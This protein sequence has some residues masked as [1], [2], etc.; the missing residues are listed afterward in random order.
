MKVKLLSR[1]WLFA[2]LWTVATR[3]LC[4]WG[5]PG[6]NTGVGCH[7]LLQGIFHTQGLN[8][9][10]LHWRQMLYPLSHQR[11]YLIYKMEPFYNLHI[12]GLYVYLM[13]ILKAHQYYEPESPCVMLEGSTGSITL[14]LPGIFLLHLNQ[15]TIFMKLLVMR[16]KDF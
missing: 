16:R 15:L 3:L 13:C 4:P 10:L 7:F 2:T 8:P 11:S 9:G 12:L 14:C 6:K 1:V 5:F